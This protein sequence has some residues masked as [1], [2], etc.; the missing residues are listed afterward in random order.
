VR[1]NRASLQGDEAE[2]KAVEAQVRRA[3]PILRRIQAELSQ[4]Q[5]MGLDLPG[6]SAV[7]TSANKMK[8][9]NNLK[10]LALAMHTY[11]SSSGYLPRHAIY[12]KD[13]KPL[14]S[15]RVAVLPYLEQVPLYRKFK[16]DEPWDSPHNKAL[17]KYMPPSFISPE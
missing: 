10:Q 3:E 7:R 5:L 14:L 17:L 1:K 15:W 12:S 9:Q 6:V 4:G 13:G 8:S 11:A 16:L 2:V